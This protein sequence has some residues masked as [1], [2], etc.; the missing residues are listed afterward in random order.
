MNKSIGFVRLLRPWQWYKNLL[1]FVPILFSGNFFNIPALILTVFGFLALCFVSSFNYVIND[2]VDYK[3]DSI[4]IEK[5]NRPVASGL[6]N[7]AEAVIFGF[8][9]LLLG[10][11]IASGLGAYFFGSVILL[12]LLSQLYNFWLKNEI[13]AD[14]IIIGINF[15]IRAASGAFIIGV[16]ISTWLVLCT[17]FLSLVLSVGKRYAETILLGEKSA[18]HR[19]V[20]SGYTKPV[21][22]TLLVLCMGL[23][24][25]AYSLYCF[26]D[27][28]QL[29][30]TLPFALYCVFRYNG[31]LETDPKFAR[32]PELL[33]LDKHMLVG[34]V[35][36]LIISI[37]LIYA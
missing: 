14:V 6:I 23:L 34:S 9:F 17:F 20:L 16:F 18:K 10:L 28:P 36:W 1:I 22:H 2:V 29:M 26:I 8:V 11:W 30:L 7:R 31:L 3:K 37:L 25:M 33:F 21:V 35:A 15:V 19:A 32:N 27:R 5:R 12:V 13:F 4:N 24:L